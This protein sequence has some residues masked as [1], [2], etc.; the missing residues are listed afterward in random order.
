[1]PVKQTVLI[2]GPTESGKSGLLATAARGYYQATKR[3]VRLVTAESAQSGSQLAGLIA[4]GIVQPW[5]LD[6]RADTPF[7]RIYQA[8]LGYW[9]IDPNEPLSPLVPAF[10]YR[11]EAKCDKCG[12][13]LYGSEAPA[14]DVNLL[15]C[16]PCQ[17]PA[18][19]RTIRVP[20]E[21][22]GIQEIGMYLF[23]GLTEFSEMMMKDMSRRVAMGEAMT[24][25]KQGGEVAIR[26]RDGDLWIGG[27]TQGQY[28]TAQS[29]I[30]SRVDESKHLLGVDYVIWT[31]VEGMDTDEKNKRTGKVFGPK[32]AGNAKTGDVPRWFGPTLGTRKVPQHGTMKGDE[33]RLYLSTYFQAW[34]TLDSKI[35]NICNNRIPT[36]QL[37][38]VPAHLVVDPNDTTLL[39]RVLQMIEKKQLAQPQGPGV[40]QPLTKPPAQPTV[41]AAPAVV[42]K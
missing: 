25:E 1:M 11:Y 3:K 9:P 27:N 21:R 41:L 23:E 34:D 33:Y 7:E 32:I 39:W 38:D 31:A 29:Q 24:G 26:F 12:K 17:L 16:K 6:N 36:H 35:P 20:N 14:K 28:G 18:I 10:T 30:K 13:L 40:Q 22:N 19:Q 37:S 5:F 4:E 8:C 42:K 2:W 15:T